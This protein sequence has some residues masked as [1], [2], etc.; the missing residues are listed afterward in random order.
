MAQEVLQVFGHVGILVTDAGISYDKT[1]AK[2]D[3]L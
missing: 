3:R 2:M 1:F